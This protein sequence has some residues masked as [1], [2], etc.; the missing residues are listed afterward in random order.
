MV[1]L[2]QKELFVVI[3]SSHNKNLKDLKEYVLNILKD[4]LRFLFLERKFTYKFLDNEKLS[5][6]NNLLKKKKYQLFHLVYVWT[7]LTSV[8][9]LIL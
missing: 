9:M 7:Y 5:I 1:Y 3:Q 4:N 6:V 8:K 2:P